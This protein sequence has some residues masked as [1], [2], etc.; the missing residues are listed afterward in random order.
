[1]TKLVIRR[2]PLN[3]KMPFIDGEE[4]KKK[5]KEDLQNL[6]DLVLLYPSSSSY[7]RPTCLRGTP[8]PPQLAPLDKKRSHKS[9]LFRLQ[10]LDREE[11]G[12]QQFFSCLFCGR[13]GKRI[14]ARP[15]TSVTLSLQEALR[16]SALSQ[17][18]RK[19]EER[20]KSLSLVP[21]F[22]IIP[23]SA[24]IAKAPKKRDSPVK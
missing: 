8:S 21:P 11:E 19:K 15:D 24:F 16:D 9:P 14:A 6:P 23:C 4:D 17:F 7:N 18:G 1:M 22:S 12:P 5:N 3:G 13:G 2:S 20:K 10:P